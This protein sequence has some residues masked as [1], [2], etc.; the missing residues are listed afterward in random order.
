VRLTGISAVA[1]D[2][3]AGTGRAEGLVKGTSIVRCQHLD[4]VGLHANPQA[5]GCIRRLR[6]QVMRRLQSCS[7]C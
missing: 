3:V 2:F 5:Q 7:L 1:Q 4:F 6:L